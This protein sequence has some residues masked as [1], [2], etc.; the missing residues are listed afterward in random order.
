MLSRG[1]RSVL[2][3]LGRRNIRHLVRK[4]SWM[5]KEGTTPI[6]E[7]RMEEERATGMEPM[8][9]RVALSILLDEGGAKMAIME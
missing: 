2:R 8:F 3:V 7:Q 6:L 9:E 5:W 4:G 1:R